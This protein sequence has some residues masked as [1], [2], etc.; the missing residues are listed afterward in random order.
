[1]AFLSEGFEM[2]VIKD[3]MKILHEIQG[4]LGQY[5]EKFHE[6]FIAFNYADFQGIR[7]IAGS[8]AQQYKEA[9]EK[10][11]QKDEPTRIESHRYDDFDH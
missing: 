9:L 5:E 1:M 3:D 10:A 7:G 6:R 4:M 11:L 8:A 2:Y